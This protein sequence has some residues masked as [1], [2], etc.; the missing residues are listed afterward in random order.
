MP[1]PAIEHE[2]DHVQNLLV[3]GAPTGKSGW[4]DQC[5]A[6]TACTR[7]PLPERDPVR[8][9]ASWVDLASAGQL[10]PPPSAAGTKGDKRLGFG[11][12]K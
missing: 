7:E 12:K 11:D 3:A 10:D 2:H 1:E 4:L 5:A 8:E 6:S 9:G